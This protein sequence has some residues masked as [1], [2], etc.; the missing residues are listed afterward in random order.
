MIM[1]RS[2]VTIILALLC[3]TL[4][5]GVTTYT[6]TS[7]DWKSK[8]DATVCDGKNDGWISDK[9][10][11]EYSQGYT[12]ASGRIYSRGVSVKT[13][14]S[15]AG[16]TS[17]VVFEDVRM[18]DINFCQNASKGKGSI[19]VQ[20]GENPAYELVINRPPKSQGQYNRDTTLQIDIPQT[21]KIRF[22]VTCTENS[23]NINTLTIRSSN[24][25]S[26]PF[27]TDTYQLVTA[28]E[29]LQDNDQ[30]IIG[31]H[32][33]EVSKIMGY[34]DESVSQNNIHAIPGKYSDD[35]IQVSPNEE[36][37]YTLHRSELNGDIAFYIEDSIRYGGAYLVANGGKTKNRLALWDNLY[38]E[39]TYG[40]YGYWDITIAN[41]GEA[42]IRNLGNSVGKYLQY[43][44]SNNPT[45]F[46]CYADLSQTPVC[47]YRRVEA[48]G[49][50]MAIVA[51]M[52]N[53]GT[54]LLSGKSAIGS[55]TVK[56][57]ANRL[58]E[59]ITAS[60][61]DGSFFSLSAMTIDRDGGYLDISYEVAVAGDYIDTLVLQSG[62][63]RCEAL[64]MLHVVAPMTI[65]Q[66]VQS[67]DFEVVYLD[68][69]VVTK[70]YDSYIFICDTTG[71]ML[72]YD[73]GDGEGK[74][75]GAGLKQGNVL[76]RV[77]GRFR[78]YYG[79]P[80]IA[81]SREW[82]VERETVVCQPEFISQLDSTLV[83]H[84]VRIED[85]KITEDNLLSSISITSVLVDDKFDMGLQIG[86]F[87]SVD[88]IVMMVWNELQ[89]WCVAQ[90]T[91][92]SDVQNVEY[93]HGGTS[94]LIRNGQL[95][96]QYAEEIYGVMGER[97]V[98][99]K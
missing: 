50:T 89:L 5:A 26:S 61:K 4:F 20:V 18:I 51:S 92:P 72:I 16:A 23:I 27:T 11:Y 2:V 84:Y 28:V 58:K 78:N 49:D 21:G 39:N 70:K 8:V 13:S 1:N 87:A 53:F 24:A 44:A 67:A 9:E 22:W 3:N 83:C 88:A 80:E 81:P 55:Q 57:N 10:A 15:G 77:V 17:V 59:D 96:I 56:V 52:T 31:V 85:A 64:V 7:K 47:I 62:D 71:S 42:T 94:K 75:Y 45:L 12:D 32:H 97:M 79:V 95:Y 19:F 38:D 68:S 60:L 66:A 6:F 25:G 33:P 14:T 91:L 46:A 40:N 35:R 93:Q 99:E 43:N 74:R 48:L 41:D 36:A 54:V 73:T 29:Q 69:V 65:E 63:V 98:L 34:F 86:S 30:I 82:S 76:R 90:E 37:I